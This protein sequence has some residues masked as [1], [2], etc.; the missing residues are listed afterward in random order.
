MKTKEV[1]ASSSQEVFPRSEAC[2]QHM[3]RMWKVMIDGDS[4]FSW[5]SCGKGFPARYPRTILF[6]Q[7]VICDTPGLYPYYIY[8]HY[9]Y[10][11]RSAFQRENLSHYPWEWKIVIPT[12]LYTIHCGFPQLLPLHFQIHETLIAQTLTTHILSVKWGFGA[13]GKHWKKPFVWWMQLG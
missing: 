4:W 3:T 13:A 1:F 12:I 2:A 8:P 6:C 5:L 10:M 11:L 9:P 7:F